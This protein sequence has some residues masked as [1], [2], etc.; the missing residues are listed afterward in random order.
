MVGYPFE[1]KQGN[2]KYLAGNQTGAYSSWSS[3]A[4]AYHF[5]VYTCICDLSLSCD[6][7]PYCLLGDDIVIG[8]KQVADLY[9][10]KIKYFGVDVSP[11]KTHISS[12]FMELAKCMFHRGVEITPFPISGLH[13]VSKTSILLG[14]FLDEVSVRG[15][16]LS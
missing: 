10:M 3:F 5:M 15:M 13:E 14:F 8:C 6:Q 4:L 12:T 7:V 16:D 2:V 9:L 1:T 11:A